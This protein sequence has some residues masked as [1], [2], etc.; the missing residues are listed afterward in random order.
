MSSFPLP[1]NVIYTILIYS[2]ACVRVLHVSWGS[3][4]SSAR[5]HS[6]SLFHWWFCSG[7]GQLV[8][9]RLPPLYQPM[10]F[11]FYFSFSSVHL[12]AT[13]RGLNVH[14]PWTEPHFSVLCSACNVPLWIA[15][16][17]N[18]PSPM[19]ILFLTFI[20]LFYLFSFK[21]TY[22]YAALVPTLRTFSQDAHQERCQ[23]CQTFVQRVSSIYLGFLFL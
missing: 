1:T 9:V 16:S 2:V 19:P 18:T 4:S 5:A 21:Y 3:M 6:L 17:H 15:C 12:L 11:F 8:S 14:M 20:S 22:F 7:V 13:M 23:V 10:F